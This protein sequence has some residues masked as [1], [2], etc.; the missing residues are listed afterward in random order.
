MYVGEKSPN[1]RKIAQF[2]AIVSCQQSFCR[3]VSNHFLAQ[4]P[5]RQGQKQ[6]DQ[7]GRDFAIWGK[8]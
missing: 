5:I 7:I 2:D 4:S 3:N 8:N 1:R 6:C